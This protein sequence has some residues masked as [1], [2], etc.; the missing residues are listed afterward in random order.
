[1]YDYDTTQ[2]VDSSPAVGA[3]S[4]PAGRWDVAWARAR[5]TGGGDTDAVKA[6]TN[7]LVPVWSEDP[8]RARPFE[9]GAGGREGDGQLDVVEG[10]DTG[11][12]GVGVGAGRG[13][14]GAPIWHTGLVGPGHR[15]GRGRRPHRRRLPGHPG[16]RPSTGWR[17]FDGQSGAEVTVLGTARRVPDA[18]LVTD[19][20][21]GT[22]GVTIAG[23]NGNNEG[24]IQHYE[25]PG[26]DGALAVGHGCV[27]DV[28]P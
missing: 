12:L 13:H 24:V 5:T 25:I 19:D 28:P 6:F 15:L 21:N 2:E 4:W 7:R 10:T 9:P 11:T 17:C 22:I 1:M 18:P 23:Y 8:R 20:P 26:S 27:A 14:G 16:A 3:V